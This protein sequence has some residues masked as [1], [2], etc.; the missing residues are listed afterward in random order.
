M[1]RVQLY[2]WVDGTSTS[3][4]TY[5]RYALGAREL[6]TYLSIWKL[7][8]SSTVQLEQMTSDYLT[9]TCSRLACGKLSSLSFSRVHVC[10]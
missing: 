6:R 3:P 9:K 5:T 10:V 7:D 1:R 2:N 4:H 8:S